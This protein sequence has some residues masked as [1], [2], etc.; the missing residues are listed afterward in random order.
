M[1]DGRDERLPYAMAT[2]GWKAGNLTGD[3]GDVV[4][5]VKKA[6][7]RAAWRCWRCEKLKS[8]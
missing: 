4:A 6:T 1:H 8:E 5:A 2:N 7:N 3:R